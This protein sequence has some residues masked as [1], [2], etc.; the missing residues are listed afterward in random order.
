MRSSQSSL[1]TTYWFIICGVSYTYTILVSPKHAFA[2]AAV[3]DDESSTDNYGTV[4]GIDLGTTYS[5]VG[6][7]K[8][9]KVEI[10]PTIKVIE[11]LHHTCRS[12]AMKDWL[13]TL[14]RIKLPLMSTTLFSILKD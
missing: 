10:W 1:V 3:S 12:M 11:S 2:V 8:N 13:G 6:V 9:G 14:P 7:M 4:I 5:C